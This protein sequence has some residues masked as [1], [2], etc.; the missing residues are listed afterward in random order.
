MAPRTSLSQV[1]TQFGTAFDTLDALPA[2]MVR[3]A[4]RPAMLL[5]LFLGHQLHL[6]GT[7][8]H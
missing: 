7:V 3:H 5:P 8:P 6:Q 4:G 1:T 2:A